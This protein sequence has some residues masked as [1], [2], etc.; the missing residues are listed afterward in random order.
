MIRTVRVQEIKPKFLFMKAWILVY[1]V[2]AQEL[3]IMMFTLSYQP[4][5]ISTSPPYP[6]EWANRFAPRRHI[7]TPLA[8]DH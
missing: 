1:F 5:D 4:T 3:T 7:A 8:N 6:S 2:L